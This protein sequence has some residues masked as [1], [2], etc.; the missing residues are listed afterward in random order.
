MNLEG[1][2]YDILL[3]Q[4]S[5]TK[6]LLEYKIDLQVTLTLIQT[7]LLIPL[8]PIVMIYILTVRLNF[9]SIILIV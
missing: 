3:A 4:Q 6:N 7:K 8:P 5:E 9:Y 2:I 1:S